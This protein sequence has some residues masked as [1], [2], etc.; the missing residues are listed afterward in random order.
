MSERDDGVEYFEGLEVTAA[1]LRLLLGEAGAKDLAR[2]L[3]GRRIYVPHK[4]GDHHPITVA[5]GRRN[6]DRLAGAYHGTAIDIPMM[7]DTCTEIRRLDAQG[8]TRAAIA[9]KLKVTERWVYM[10]LR[11]GPSSPPTQG[12]LFD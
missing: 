8:W 2:E 9:R 6:A 12:G 5:V 4:P 7:P 3:G 11:N 10:A 1:N